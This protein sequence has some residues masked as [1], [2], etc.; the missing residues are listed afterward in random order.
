VIPRLTTPGDSEKIWLWQI[1]T[2]WGLI[3]KDLRFTPL[4]LSYSKEISSTGAKTVKQLI[5]SMSGTTLEKTFTATG[6]TEKAKK[7]L[8][9]DEKQIRSHIIAKIGVTTKIKDA[10]EILTIG[11]SLVLGDSMGGSMRNLIGNI[12]ED[13]IEN[14]LNTKFGG[15]RVKSTESGRPKITKCSNPPRTLHWNVKIPGQRNFDLV[16]SKSTTLISV[17]EIKSGIDPAGADEHWSTASSKLLKLHQAMPSLKCGFAGAVIVDSTR[18]EIA[19]G[20]K[21]KELVCGIN[22][23]SDI[24]IEKGLKIL[25]S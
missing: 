2:R 22:I 12:G 6:A 16:I 4:I 8:G 1:S 3:S 21:R 11:Y 5:S 20:I 9:Y 13:R 19:E 14:V 18:R 10:I 24:E 7:G 25:L 17:L 23:N 15:Q